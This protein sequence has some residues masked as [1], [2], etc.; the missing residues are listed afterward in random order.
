MERIRS[1]TK[2]RWNCCLFIFSWSSFSWIYICTYNFMCVYL[3]YKECVCVYIHLY[4]LFIF[5]FAYVKFFQKIKMG[6]SC[7]P[8]I[9]LYSTH[10]TISFCLMHCNRTF[11]TCS[12]FYNQTCY[13]RLSLRCLVK[14]NEQSKY[15]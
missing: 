5:S 12:I 15:V 9:S 7:M 2:I 1:G 4:C 8:K 13:V 10:F 14:W 6:N 11:K 3:E